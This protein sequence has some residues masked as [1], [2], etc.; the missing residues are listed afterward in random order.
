[1]PTIYSHANGT[2]S[3]IWFVVLFTFLMMVIV[4][5][6][7]SR[8]ITEIARNTKAISDQIDGLMDDSR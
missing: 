1:M 4:M 2:V 5:W 3:K 6:K 8:G 7:L